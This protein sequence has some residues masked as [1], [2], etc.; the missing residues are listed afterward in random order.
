[1]RSQKFALID[2]NQLMIWKKHTR[3]IT[4]PDN[5]N[6]FFSWLLCSL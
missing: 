4:N 1:M 3:R 5:L 2:E 6:V